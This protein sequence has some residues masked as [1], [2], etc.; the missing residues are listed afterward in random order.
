MRGFIGGGQYRFD[1][2]TIAAAYAG[3]SRRDIASRYA[4][5]I[6]VLFEVIAEI[7]NGRFRQL[8]ITRH[9]EQN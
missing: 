7:G 6:R 3:R 8:R 9:L 5:P 1:S 4:R 2:P